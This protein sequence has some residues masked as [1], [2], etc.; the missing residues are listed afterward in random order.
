[1]TGRYLLDTNVIIALFARDA[2]VQLAINTATELFVSSTV[3]GELFYGAQNSGRRQ[4]NISRIKQ[5]IANYSVLD[6]DSQSAEFY[7]QI[8]AQLKKK[9]KP[10]PENDIWIAAVAEQYGLIVAT[11]DKHFLEIETITTEIW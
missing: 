9:G 4:Q 6:C 7:G 2:E 1:M 8:K 3:V 10:L 11:R 5:F